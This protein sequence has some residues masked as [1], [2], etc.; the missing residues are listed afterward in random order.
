MLHVAVMQTARTVIGGLGSVAFPPAHL[1]LDYLL[2][3]Q[4]LQVSYILYHLLQRLLTFLHFS[5]L[6]KSNWCIDPPR[7]QQ[8][9]L[10]FRRHRF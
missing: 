1:R 4:L 5:N 3:V 8:D 10:T 9:P 6:T 7:L 2:L